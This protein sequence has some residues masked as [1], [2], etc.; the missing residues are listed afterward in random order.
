MSK[1]SLSIVETVMHYRQI[2]ILLVAALVIFGV[3]GL[4]QMS[5]NEFPS[6]TIRQGL[7]IAVYPG[8]TPEEIET[9]VAKPLEA[10]LWTFPEIKKS[11][12]Y[13]QS[14]NGMCVAFVELNDE[15]NNK[16]EFWSKF[17]HGL[18]TVKMSMPKGVLALMAK[19]DF[20]NTSALLVAL[21]S[22]DK[23][24]RE[25]EDCLDQ[26]SDKIRTIPSVAKISTTGLLKEQIAVY[27]DRDKLNDYGISPKTISASLLSEGFNTTAGQ[28]DNSKYVLPV[29]TE[30]SHNSVND[31]AEQIV[32]SDPLG[33][34]IR[35]RDI[36][37]VK[38]EY[39]D[40]DSYVTT[41]KNKA[42]ILSLE[43]NEG[44][45]IVKF[46]NDVK[47]IIDEYK[48]QMP[49]DIK[50]HTICDQSY[51]VDQ[52]V[53]EFL[54]E[55][56]IAIAAV[57]LVVVIL[58]PLR[59]ATV[60]ASTI[61]ISIFIS[62]GLFYIFDIELNTVTL[63]GMLVTLGMVV[64]N[65]IVIIDSYLEKLDQGMSRWHASIVSAKEFARSIIDATLAISITFF[66]F[67]F[68]MEGM[69][70]D[71]LKAFPWSIT[72]ILFISLMIAEFLV[73]YLQ[74]FFIRTGLN[75]KAEKR[76]ADGGQRRTFL[77][78][79][80]SG[81]EKL[82]ALCFRHKT[83]TLVIAGLTVVC[84]LILYT[85]LPQRLLPIA[86]RNQFALE[87]NLPAGTAIEKTAAVADSMETILKK[88]P[89][90][91]S[92]TQFIG[93]SSPRFH[94]AYAPN[95]PG[96]NMAQFIVNTKD[97]HATVELLDEYATKYTDYFPE[98]TIRF[99]QL[100]YNSTSGPIEMRFYGDNLSELRA[101]GDTVLQIMRNN[102]NT[103]FIRS[104]FG[105]SMPSV[106]IKIDEAEANRIGVNKTLLSLELATKFSNGIPVTDIWEGDK[107]IP[108]VLK[109]SKI[110][111]QS[112]QELLNTRVSGLLPGV[113]VP[114]RQIAEVKPQWEYSSVVR[115]N[116]VRCISIMCDVKR[117]ENVNKE[118][119]VIAEQCKKL[120]LPQ[121]V[122]FEVGGSIEHD[123][124]TMPGIIQALVIALGIIFIILLFHYR[125]VNMP[126]LILGSIVFTLF[127]ACVG[128]WI[129][130]L[131]FSITA[132]LGIVSLMGILVRN[133]IIMFDY[134]D[135][136]H[137]KYKLSIEESALKAA[138]RRM[139]P[140]FLTSAA[141][142]MGVIPMIIAKSELWCPMGAVICFGTMIS[143]VLIVTVL[144]VLYSVL[145]KNN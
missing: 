75:A 82:I 73:P 16:D 68:T 98:C 127:G 115:R 59:V 83:A 106:K 45:N 58:L 15:V 72:I 101:L 11:K 55:L 35:V 6:F 116:G 37:T 53:S 79:V 71:F 128:V 130:G 88:D 44:N 28:I 119:A 76:N 17:K 145:F 8:A 129:M 49:D 114:L 29:R 1:R 137:I 25:L 99:K 4:E 47:K 138:E 36:A 19:D 18:S 34:V 132:I 144:P 111:S 120:S 90:V 141:A 121:G 142:S 46:G 12:T 7:V 57:V 23:T 86:E 91:V 5:K 52:S 41:N 94:T 9:Q 84:G 30:I 139:R 109:D 143:M 74:Y 66:P 54:K 107:D 39:P 31:I 50:I 27:V 117:G 110:D 81:Y 21:E 78:I 14:L 140:I 108:V 103:C 70:K 67:L 93:S 125:R 20:G 135:E 112:T 2:V 65:S 24:Y 40:P 61:P 56:M 105:E 95:L 102:P 96:T 97:N 113:T 77:D 32:Y 64:D 80:Q 104:N 69:F 124:E 131:D 136:L 51:V 38:R 43:M 92:I 26:L 3:Y 10:F 33:N 85:Q 87:F 122:K 126:L 60:A 48:L 13:T 123:A 63:A 42:V 62:I 100:D 134:A 89:R 133:A 22:K 118:T